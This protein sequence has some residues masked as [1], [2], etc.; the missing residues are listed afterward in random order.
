MSETAPT[1][2]SDYHRAF[3]RL[4][5]QE[6]HQDLSTGGGSGTY[7]GMDR[8]WAK[9]EE[10]DRRFG[11]IEGKLDRVETDVSQLKFWVVGT[12]AASFLGMAALVYSVGSFMGG[13]M[14][15]ALSAIQTVLA[16]R[17]AEPPA[18]PQQPSII[19]V[20]FPGATAPPPIQS[21]AP[22]NPPRP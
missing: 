17:P 3:Q 10:H 18:T 13:T 20:P 11:Q 1:N 6:R 9:L 19:V 14:S 12:A 16:A 22:T 5:E 2:I 8:V 21:P 15:T 4:K 7:D